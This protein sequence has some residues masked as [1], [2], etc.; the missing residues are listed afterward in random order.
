MG[1]LDMSV[2]RMRLCYSTS[3]AESFRTWFTN[4]QL[5]THTETDDGV[6]NEIPDSPWNP[7]PAI[8]DPHYRV[9]LSFPESKNAAKLI[10]E[11]SDA[12]AGYCEWS[13]L[14][15]HQCPHEKVSPNECVWKTQEDPGTGTVPGY[16]R[17]FTQ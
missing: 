3:G 15:Y 10:Q 14:A 16:V 2:H 11:I 4:W 12:L 7:S 6:T 9:D 13:R 5:N 17:P 1:Y 8:G